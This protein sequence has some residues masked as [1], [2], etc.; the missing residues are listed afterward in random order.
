MKDP[1]KLSSVDITLATF[2]NPLTD[3]Y[4]TFPKFFDELLFLS[5][6][7]KSPSLP[8]CMHGVC[9]PN[10]QPQ[11]NKSPTTNESSYRLRYFWE[12]PTATDLSETLILAQNCAAYLHYLPNNSQQGELQSFMHKCFTFVCAAYRSQPFPSLAQSAAAF[13]N[14]IKGGS[15]RTGGAP[16]ED[17][18]KGF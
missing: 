7:T 8:F 18:R 10:C 9:H 6:E 3:N 17:G 15:R 2:Q 4:S 1:N 13:D 14:N 11:H 12:T 16:S 5:F